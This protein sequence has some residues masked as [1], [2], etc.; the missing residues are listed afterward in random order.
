M[1]SSSE[2]KSKS[3]AKLIAVLKGCEVRLQTFNSKKLQKFAT[4]SSEATSNDVSDVRSIV[5]IIF[6]V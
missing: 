2:I 5:S 4:T 3:I 6:N 1:K